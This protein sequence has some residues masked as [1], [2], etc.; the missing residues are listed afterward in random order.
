MTP[1]Q[2]PLGEFKPPVLKT[3][4]F[5][6]FVSFV[7]FGTLLSLGYG[8]AVAIQLHRIHGKMEAFRVTEEI[9]NYLDKYDQQ[10]APV[11]T[12]SLLINI[13]DDIEET[14]PHFRSVLRGLPD[15]SYYSSGHK[16]IGGPKMH[17]YI[18][19]SLPGRGKKLYFIID[20]GGF[21]KRFGL[22]EQVAHVFRYGFLVAVGLSIVAGLANAH[23]L[24]HP[25]TRLL[26]Q[27]SRS[28]PEDLP[29]GF[30]GAYTHDEVGSLARA[31]DRT[32]QR[33]RA[34][35][36]REQQFT[37]DASHE[38][39]TPVTVIKGAVE[40]MGQL[41]GGDTPHIRR[42][43]GR[44]E[45]AV[46]EMEHL[47]E[48]LLQKA[49]GETAVGTASDAIRPLVEQALEENSY[50]VE[51]KEVALSLECT[52]TPAFDLPGI[53]FKMAVSNLI[54]NACT[55]TR[56]GAVTV[57]LTEAFIEVEDTGP[58]IDPAVI[59]RITDPFVKGKSSQGHGIGLAIVKRVCDHHGW[60]LSILPQRR[61][62]RVRITFSP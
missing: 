60:H 7:L 5:R 57:R 1:A 54:R 33:I 19:R 37:R 59:D 16:G 2:R 42:P 3:H 23:L 4:A 9:K 50:L 46:A 40:L 48:S 47:I 55:C 13:Y 6:L 36:E 27:V 18:I 32:N 25:M 34:F 14:P 35:I 53:D 45:R 62:L 28:K 8:L 39:R 52:G 12:Q 11:L 26:T 20:D 31:L 24:I 49:R 15:G 61:G 30:S 56:E 22:H 41:P 58:G 51:G 21:E 44:I 17:R 29:V 10:Q 43:L 38:L